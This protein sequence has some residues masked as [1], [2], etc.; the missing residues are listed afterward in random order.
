[1]KEAESAVKNN[2]TVMAESNVV[3]TESSDTSQANAQQNIA[4]PASGR[5]S[6]IATGMGQVEKTNMIRSMIPLIVTVMLNWRMK[7]LL[8]CDKDKFIC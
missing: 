4:K 7:P 3:Q 5:K 2:M 6:T 8:K 1:M